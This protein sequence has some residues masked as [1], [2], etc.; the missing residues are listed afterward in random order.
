MVTGNAA[1]PPSRDLATTITTTPANDHAAGDAALGAVGVVND[2][3]DVGGGRGPGGFD[4]EY[5]L[6]LAA[7]AMAASALIA[8]DAD[9]GGD[10]GIAVVDGVGPHG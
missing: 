9:A 4:E 5:A 10:G 1:P 3:D 6:V 2:G 7:E 8:D